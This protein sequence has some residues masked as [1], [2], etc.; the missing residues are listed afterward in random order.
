MSKQGVE[1]AIYSALVTVGAAAGF[2]GGYFFAKKKW[3]AIADE[4]IFEV[5]KTYNQARVLEQTPIEEVMAK[6]YKADRV[7]DHEVA[8]MSPEALKNAGVTSVNGVIPTQANIV[9]DPAVT[10]ARGVV[11]GEETAP[12][13]NV[14][15]TQ[16][17]DSAFERDED[18]PYLISEED[19]SNPSN[20]RYERLTLTYYEQD[21]ALADEGDNLVDSVSQVIGDRALHMFGVRSDDPDMVYVMNERYGALYEIVRKPGSYGEL[22]NADPQE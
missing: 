5:K 17:D 20:D 4:E 15:D 10:V 9:E 1:I 3:R 11:F 14:F 21:G 13:G 22:I 6:Y 8:P 2:T 19:Y 18:R 12:E 16:S 7:E